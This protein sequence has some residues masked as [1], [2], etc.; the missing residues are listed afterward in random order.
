MR[1]GA[2]ID[3]LCVVW[4]VWQCRTLHCGLWI[5]FTLEPSIWND[6]I[7]HGVLIEITEISRSSSICNVLGNVVVDYPLILS[8]YTYLHLFWNSHITRHYNTG[9]QDRC[10]I[11]NYYM[12]IS[13][14]YALPS[15]S[16]FFMKDKGIRVDCFFW[17]K[18]NIYC[19]V[20][21]INIKKDTAI[22]KYHHIKI[23]FK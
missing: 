20:I 17:S 8:K 11:H 3:T 23:K 21:T 1:S 22:Q 12:F 2:Y 7:T 16:S 10:P 9:I 4:C 15:N 13:L 14:W 5:L 19:T 6:W 18:T